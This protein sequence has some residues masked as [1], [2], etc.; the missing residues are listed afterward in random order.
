M[1]KFNV[2]DIVTCNNSNDAIHTMCELLRKDIQTCVFNRE[3]D[4]KLTIKVTRVG[5]KFD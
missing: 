5:G 1:N 2:G 3:P 4:G